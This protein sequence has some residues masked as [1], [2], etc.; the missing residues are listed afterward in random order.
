M[1]KDNEE[2]IIPKIRELISLQAQ[3]AKVNTAFAYNQ[4]K[5][6]IKGIIENLNKTIKEYNISDSILKQYNNEINNVNRMENDFS[7]LVQN[8][9]I[10]L[11]SAIIYQKKEMYNKIKEIKST[12]EYK[13]YC[14]E[15]KEIKE[16][17]KKAIDNNDIISIEENKAKLEKM[18][19]EDPIKKGTKLYNENIEKAKKNLDGENKKFEAIQED[20]VEALK[21]IEIRKK[22]DKQLAKI[23]KQNILKKMLG[24]V[25]NKLI[26]TKKFKK[27]FINLI[28]K[29]IFDIK[30][31]KLPELEK[32]I[33]TKIAEKNEKMKETLDKKIKQK[34]ELL[35]EKKEKMPK[36]NK[37][38]Q[39]FEG[40][41]FEGEEP[42]Q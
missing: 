5:E 12:E 27:E 34:E 3:I 30:N 32:K 13:E 42:E 22:D 24:T 9:I 26:G 14:T 23:G 33:N 31:S 17:M 6:Q 1:E 2:Q 38:E 28:N 10:D 39:K 19:K 29:K 4:G 35:A 11:K 40:K 21:E 16:E 7:E 20:R 18:I 37:K 36:E 15:L 25:Y 41:K 8:N